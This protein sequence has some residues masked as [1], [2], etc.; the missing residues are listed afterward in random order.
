MKQSQKKQFRK[1]LVQFIKNYETRPN[2][3]DAVRNVQG[4]A[5]WYRD[6]DRQNLTEEAIDAMARHYDNQTI[7]EG[8]IYISNN[9][10]W[11]E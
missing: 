5:E 2:F 9:P 7:S 8:R 1:E 11:K 6:L 10:N 3:A 4:L